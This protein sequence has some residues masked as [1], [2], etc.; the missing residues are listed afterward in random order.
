MTFVVYDKV[1]LLKKYSDIV[2]R[3]KKGRKAC[4]NAHTDTAVVNSSRAG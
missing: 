3:A 1:A 2:S 4:P